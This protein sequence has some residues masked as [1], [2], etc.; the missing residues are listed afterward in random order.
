MGSKI[1]QEELGVEVE[2][3]DRDRDRDRD[4]RQLGKEYD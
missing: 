4:P 2:A 3:H 1:E